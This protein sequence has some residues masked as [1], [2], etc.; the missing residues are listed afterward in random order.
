MGLIL[1]TFC[2]VL[3]NYRQ[4]DIAISGP[5]YKGKTVLQPILAIVVGVDD[6]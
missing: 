5:I 4:L 1:K 2:P 6:V 3:D